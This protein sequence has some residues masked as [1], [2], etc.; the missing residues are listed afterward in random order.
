M[1]D[2]ILYCFSRYGPFYRRQ[3]WIS[4]SEKVAVSE[5][6]NAA[7]STPSPELSEPVCIKFHCIDKVYLKE[8]ETLSIFLLDYKFVNNIFFIID[9]FTVY[10]L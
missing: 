8:M 6:E 2:F 5:E 9:K 4:R 1:I 7:C 10:L 3:K